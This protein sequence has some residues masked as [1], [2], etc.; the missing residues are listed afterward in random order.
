M[1][2]ED[3]PLDVCW[4]GDYRRNHHGSKGECVLCANF[5]PSFVEKC[6]HFRS[7][8]QAFA[9][10][11]SQGGEEGQNRMVDK[12]MVDEV[13]VENQ[14]IDRERGC[15]DKD[16]RELEGW[17]RRAVEDVLE[18]AFRAGYVWQKVR[19]GVFVEARGR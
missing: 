7:H 19:A 3:H 12:V 14:N 8:E 1:T 15:T 6:L 9:E 4:C 16:I 13:L 10:A 17:T 5:N 2:Q 18:A 11:R